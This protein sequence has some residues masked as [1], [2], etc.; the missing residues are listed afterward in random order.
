METEL[1]GVAR[2]ANVFGNVIV[3]G[4]E[5]VVGR[6]RA[7]MDLTRVACHQPCCAELVL[8]MFAGTSTRKF[9]VLA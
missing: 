4:M 2:H 6:L 9:S 7:D 5:I 3:G 8:C 1:C